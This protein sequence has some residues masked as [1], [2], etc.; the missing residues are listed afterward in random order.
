MEF[1]E[2][3]N[4]IFQNMTSILS[5]P[6]CLKDALPPFDATVE[7]PKDLPDEMW[8]LWMQLYYEQDVE[9]QKDRNT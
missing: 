4:I 2:G 6:M 1:E 5:L 9:N 3:T 8:R 7:Q